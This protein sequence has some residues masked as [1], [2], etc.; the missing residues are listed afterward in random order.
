MLR[1][2][3]I[4]GALALAAC[5][6]A[7]VR[8]ENCDPVP[9]ELAKLGNVYTDCGVDVPASLNRIPRLDDARLPSATRCMRATLDFVVDTAGRA[10]TTPVLI[11]R[12]NEPRFAE[13]MIAA[14]SS[15]RF[16]PAIKNKRPVL[17]HY[18]WDFGISY[19]SGIDIM[20]ASDRASTSRPSPAGIPQC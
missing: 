9:T 20:R 15:A 17:Q 11:F 1:A 12:S 18:R 4:I 8:R 5:A 14:L 6:S 16:S 13:A 10:I 19:S 7:P 2:S 3:S